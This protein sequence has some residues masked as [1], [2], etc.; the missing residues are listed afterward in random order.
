MEWNSKL[1]KVG[2]PV[3]FNENER[4]SN[5]LYNNLKGTIRKIE[6]E[7]DNTIFFEIELIDTVLNGLEI[8]GLDLELVDNYED[9][10]K[11]VVRFKVNKYKSTDE[12]DNDSHSVVPFQTSYAIS[13]HKAQGLEYESV[14]IVIT[15]EVGEQINHNIFYTAITRTKQ[16]LTIYWSPETEKY[17]L[18]NLS[19][20][21]I[22]KDIGLLKDKFSKSNTLK[23]SLF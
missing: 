3:V 11:S 22:G 1:Y 18:S 17:I 16:H 23:S 4:F 19:R 7:S 14:K 20:K 15:N 9:T 10:I 12:D 2:D 5:V 13:I 21:N 8:D 6:V